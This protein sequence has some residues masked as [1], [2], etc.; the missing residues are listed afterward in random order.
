MKRKSTFSSNLLHT[1]F[2]GIFLCCSGSALSQGRVVINEFSTGLSANKSQDFIELKNV[3]VG[4]ADISN[5]TL[6]I[7]NESI[8]LPKNTLVQEGGFFVFNYPKMIAKEKSNIRIYV[9]DSSSNI[10]DAVSGKSSEVQNAKVESILDVS[11][12]GMFFSRKM[13]GDCKWILDSSSTAG[14]SNNKMGTISSLQI[15]KLV[16]MNTNCSSG[17]VNFTIEGANPEKFFS[18]NYTLG[19]DANND[20]KLTTS[21]RFVNGSDSTAPIVEVNN[22]YSS[23]TYKIMLEPINGCNQQV[24]DFRIDP[25]VTMAVRLKKFTG[26]SNGKVNNFNIEIET[27]ADLKELKLE[28]SVNGSQFEKISNVPFENRAGLQNI[29]YNSNPTQQTYFRIAMTDINNKVTYS[30]IV[31]LSLVASSPNKISASPNPFSDMVN[32]RVQSDKNE[33]AVVSFYATN[34]ALAFTQSIDLF[35]GNNDIRLQ[36]SQL[37]KGLYIVSIRNQSNQQAQITRLMKG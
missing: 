33:K 34:G 6:V 27:D 3:G 14:A 1:L 36:T 7:D 11:G 22:L 37:Q 20:G 12:Q 13:D 35:S 2:I 24:F 32:L 25:C 16:S 19:F 21:D 23:G 26:S 15:S 9:L 4:T 5:Y 18:V 17:K 10:I 8:K 30:P 31:H 29:S 28:G